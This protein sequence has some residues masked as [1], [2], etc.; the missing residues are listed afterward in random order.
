[1]KATGKMK[2]KDEQGNEN[3]FNVNKRARE[4]RQKRTQNFSYI[5]AKDY[6]NLGL[7]PDL[8]DDFKDYAEDHHIAQIT[9]DKANGARYIYGIPAYNI[10]QKEVSFNASGRNIDHE[11]GM[12]TYEDGIDNSTGNK[13]GVDHFY[14]GTSLPPYAHSYLLTAIVSP[15]YVDLL[16]D[17][18]SSNDLGTYTHFVYEKVSN[19]QWRF[20]VEENH[21]NFNE[22]LKTAAGDNWGDDQ[23]NYIY[24]VKDVWF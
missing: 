10:S 8:Y 3:A 5:L 7:E 16:P 21:A 17:G 19:Y 9:I 4:Q 6:E 1:V 2:Y 18:P 11:K 14:S 12:V 15:D 13:R 20:P 24:G 22:G 23:G